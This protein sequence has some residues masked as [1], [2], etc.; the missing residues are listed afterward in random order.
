MVFTVP[1]LVTAILK[2]DRDLALRLISAVQPMAAA[3]AIAGRFVDV[4]QMQK[5]SKEGYGKLQFIQERPF[6]S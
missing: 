5:P 3:A 2:T 6:L 4:R 1:Q